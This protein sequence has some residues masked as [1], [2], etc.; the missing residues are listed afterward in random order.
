MIWALLLGCLGGLGLT[1]VARELIGNRP[2]VTALSRLDPARLADSLRHHE[3]T[4]APPAT[5]LERAGAWL[6][7]HLGSRPGL[8]APTRDL[9]LLGMTPRAYYTRKVVAMLLGLAAVPV[10]DLFVIA[11]GGRPGLGLPALV[12]LIAALAGWVFV[13]IEV[14][15]DAK[16]ARDTFA[17]AAVM[18]LQIV[19]IRRKAGRGP[20]VALTSGAEV[21][22]HAMFRRIRTE[23]QAARW[24][25][26]TPWEGLHRLA[27]QMG[28]PELDE[29]ADIMRSA[30]DGSEA[31]A[32]QLLGRA[33][34]LR[35][36]I[37]TAD[38]LKTTQ[39]TT[40]LAFPT[41]LLAF[42]F[43]VGMAPALFVFIGY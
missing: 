38:L 33:S 18:Y 37:M 15:A 23:L 25:A 28:V 2:A 21:S 41:A 7:W 19:A 3:D 22:D 13:D 42:L 14:R 6:E 43:I 20:T 31:I 29:I 16:S 5:P 10:I 40:R 12:S 1:L 39:A 30:G 35:N 9:E 4:A 8:A 27:G 32:P 17:R 26:M 34:G 36:K 24:V 11:L